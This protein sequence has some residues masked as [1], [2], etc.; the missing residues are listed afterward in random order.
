MTPD[1][2]QAV[3]QRLEAATIKTAEPLRSLAHSTSISSVSHLTLP[4]VDAIVD[5]VAQVLPAG[6]VPGMVLSGLARLPGRKPPPDIIHRDINLLFHGVEQVLDH[7]VYGAFFAGPAG[8]IWGYQNLLKLAGKDPE[9]SFPDGTW[10][11]YIDYALREDTARHANETHGFD[12]ALAQHGIRLSPVDR[13]SAWVMAAIHCLHDFDA[14]LE[15]EWR[16]RTYIQLLNEVI[17]GKTEASEYAGLYREWEKQRPYRRKDDASASDSYAG[18]RRKAFDAFLKQ[19]LDALE[20]S[21]YGDWVER[22]HTA[23]AEA[24]PAYRQQMSIRAYLSPGPYGE[25]HVP[26]PLEQQHIGVVYQGSYTLLPICANRARQP[27]DLPTVRSQVAAI[28]ADAPSLQASLLPLATVRRANL[29]GLRP[30]LSGDL[31]AALDSLRTAP[32]LVNAD[33]RP[34]NFPLAEMRQA[35]RGV[36]DHPLTIFDTGESFVFDQSHIFFDGAWGA[37]L[38]EILTNAALAWAVHL[39]ALPPAVG[40]TQRPLPLTVTI[41]DADVQLIEQAPRVMAEVGAETDRVDVK[42]ILSLRKVF[43]RRN[44][45][46]QLTVNDLLVLYRAIHALTYQPDPELLAQLQA[47]TYVQETHAAALTALQVIQE[48][49]QVT[50]AILIPIDASQ[51]SPRERLYPLTFDVP[52]ADLELPGLHDEA[53]RALEDYE[54]GGGDRSAAYARFDQLQRTYLATLAGFGALMSRAKEIAVRGESASVGTIK[55]LAHLPVPLQR[56]LDAVPG[57]FDVLNDIIKGREVF[58]NVG[59]VA[60]TSSLV[61]FISAKDDNEKK[62]LVWGVMTDAGG[63]MRITLRDFRPH[64]CLLA[65]A[66]QREMARRLA[67]DYLETYAGGLN[68]YVAELRRI[69]SASRETRLLRPEKIA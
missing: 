6:N 15:N 16:E 36:G 69:T 25:T 54:H 44:D 4:E 43:K 29:A 22:V 40:A 62:T 21:A 35:E 38:A 42:A 17:A 51:R 18:Y 32:I 33:R 14:L 49:E 31:V 48:Q 10:Q 47:L 27:A 34:R 19:R 11:F 58:S 13:L 12:T 20:D 52:L 65:E 68:R 60:P 46:I 8:V 53:I 50:P 55:L 5:R 7:A 59:A 61:R 56:M 41:Q 39:S 23:E 37:A 63:V 3:A 9:E 67:Q 57:K 2:S 30:R 24:L 1:I 64:V 26:V 66:G 45:L 28:L